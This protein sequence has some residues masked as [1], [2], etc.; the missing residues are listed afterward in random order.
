MKNIELRMIEIAACIYKAMKAGSCSAFGGLY[1]GNFGALLFLYYYA[2][3][4]KEKK[5]TLLAEHVFDKLLIQLENNVPGFSY[6]TGYAGILYLFHWLQEKK[7]IGLD[8]SDSEEI[9]ESYMINQARNCMSVNDYDYLHGSLGVALYFLRKKP[10]H[11]FLNEFV[12]HLAHTAEKDSLN[13]T[14]KWKTPV[15]KDRIYDYYISLSHGMASIIL[16]LSRLLQSGKCISSGKCI[17]LLEGCMNYILLQ[18]ID[19]TQY[20]SYFPN[21]SLESSPSPMQSRLAWCFGDSGIAWALWQAGKVIHNQQW[22]DK[23]IEIMKH[24]T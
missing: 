7:F 13:H 9:I 3:F 19:S 5:Y 17:T 4:T 20:G 24:A 1:S 15:G 21:K 10:N 8:L 18:E 11:P 23:A 16:F 22:Q 2:D 12:E 14:V 6:S